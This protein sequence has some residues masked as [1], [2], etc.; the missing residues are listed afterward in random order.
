MIL[1]NKIFYTKNSITLNYLYI[2]LMKFLAFLLS[3]Y[4]LALNFVPCE[5]NNATD[6]DIK[7]ELSQNIDVNHSH[8]GLDLCSPFCHCHCCHIHITYFNSSESDLV[9]NYISTEVFLH[10]DSLGEEI[11]NPILQPPRI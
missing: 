1:K 5:D 9:S 8:N 7:T 3:V 4:I 10:F 11:S 6:K 2:C